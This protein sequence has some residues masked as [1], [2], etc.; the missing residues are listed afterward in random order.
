MANKIVSIVND[1]G[2]TRI[3]RHIHTLMKTNVVLHRPIQKYS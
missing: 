1:L 2:K 3:L